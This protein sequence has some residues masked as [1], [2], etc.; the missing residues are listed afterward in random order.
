MS[1]YKSS[2]LAA[3]LGLFMST[4]AIAGDMSLAEPPPLNGQQP[5]EF[6]TGWYL[7][8]D[9]SWAREKAP[10]V[11]PDSSLGSS[12]KIQNTYSM[13]I[14]GGYKFNNWFRM[15]LTYD[16]FKPIVS[17]PKSANFTCYDNIRLVNDINGNP[18]GV[19]ADNN[20]CYSQQNAQVSRYALLLNGYLDL[21]TWAGVTPYVGAGVGPSLNRTTGTYDWMFAANGIHYGPALTIPGGAPI[22]LVWYDNNG[23]VIAAPVTKFG[24]Q[25]NRTV[26]NRKNFNM[27]FAL[28]AGVAYDVSPNA[29]ID[30]GYRYVNLGKL[31]AGTRAQPI[32]EYRIGMRYMID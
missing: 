15:D 6:G 22:P 18:V 29:K 3:A 30:M 2:F 26:I 5:L 8:G 27:A 31:G 1:G 16:Y 23:N 7:R 19:H 4:A 32:H 9:I 25:D 17:N 28:M 10:V 20:S 24:T 12:A 13:T 21:G 14:G 11:F